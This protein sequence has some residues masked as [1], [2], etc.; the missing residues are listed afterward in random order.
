MNILLSYNFLVPVCERILTQAEC[1]NTITCAC[2]YHIW[3]T[4]A[5]NKNQTVS[6]V[7]LLT[8]GIVPGQFSVKALNG[9][10]ELELRI[11]WSECTHCAEK[12]HKE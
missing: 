1:L 6:A 3:L 4:E 12:L 11:D 9:C 5:R 2:F 10:R 8:S 7:I